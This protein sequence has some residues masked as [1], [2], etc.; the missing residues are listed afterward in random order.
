MEWIKIDVDPMEWIIIINQNECR[1][2]SIEK[3][4]GL[5]GSRRRT[6]ESYS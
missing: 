4:I 5:Y 6:Y 1:L 2:G 3:M